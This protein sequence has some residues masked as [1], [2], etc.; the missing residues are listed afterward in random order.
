M[1]KIASVNFVNFQSC[2]KRTRLSSCSSGFSHL[3]RDQRYAAGE[4]TLLRDRL[5]GCEVDGGV[6][7]PE[8]TRK[9]LLALAMKRQSSLGW[10]YQCLHLFV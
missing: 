2:Q 1:A 5:W 6:Q 9:T 3:R 4:V 10:L 7:V 8:S